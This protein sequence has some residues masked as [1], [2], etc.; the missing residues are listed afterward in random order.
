MENKKKN[1][2]INYIKVVSAKTDSDLI[3]K[4]KQNGRSVLVNA[5]IC[6]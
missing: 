1:R 5:D 4:D 2:N 3:A 6:E